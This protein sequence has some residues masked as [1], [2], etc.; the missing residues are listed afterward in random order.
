MTDR[1]RK[2]V[3]LPHW[4][5]AAICKADVHA[6]LDRCEH[7]TLMI[8]HYDQPTVVLL[9]HEEWVRLVGERDRKHVPVATDSEG[10][11]SD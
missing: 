6:L 8:E 9:S 10:L 3:S 11:A 1:V 7:E 4:A 5:F 2:M